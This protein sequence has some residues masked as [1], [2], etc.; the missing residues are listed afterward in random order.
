[1]IGLFLVSKKSC[2]DIAKLRRKLVKISKRKILFLDETALRL[3]E[4][5]TTTLVHP[6]ES[7]YV[8][9][10]DNTSYSK[11]FDMIACCSGTQVFPPIIYTPK[12]RTDEGVKGINK[13][14]LIKYIQDIL[15]QAIGATDEYPVHVVLDKSTIHNE[16][17][18]LE[19]FHLNGAQNV[20]QILKMPTQAAKR[21]SPLDNS[22]FHEW[23]QKCRNRE[24]I[25]MKNIQQIMN[26]EWNNIASEHIFLHYRHCG[27][28]R[29]IDPYFDCPIASQ[30]KHTT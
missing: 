29:S 17:E 22:I 11:R 24:K 20:V 2:N 13:K 10:D 18:L 15:G 21:M 9:V 1:M 4:A 25:T 5:A 28:I 6:G 19:A 27:L 16:Q 12:E 30:H 23:K 26:D 7:E 8:V 14:M 3:S